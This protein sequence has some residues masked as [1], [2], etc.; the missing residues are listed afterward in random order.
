MQNVIIGT[1]M[2]G[3]RGTARYRYQATRECKLTKT[4]WQ[5]VNK[6]IRVP[7]RDLKVA[8]SMVND[9]LAKPPTLLLLQEEMLE[10]PHKAVDTTAG[11]LIIQGE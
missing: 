5:G 3:R 6:T 10:P 2:W 4:Y 11:K 9:L 1:T 8:V 7:G